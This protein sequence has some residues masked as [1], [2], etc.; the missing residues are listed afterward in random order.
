[1]RRHTKNYISKILRTF[2]IYSLKIYERDKIPESIIYRIIEMNHLRMNDKNIV[3]GIDS[4]Y[5]KKIVKFVRDFGFISV[6]EINGEIVAGL[7]TYLIKNNYFVEE[8]SS[9]PKFDQYNVGH[10]C[11]FLTI[12]DCIERNGNEFHLLWGNNPYKQR[13]LAERFQ[14]Y[15]VT[16]F[17]SNILKYK[18]KLV[19][20]L[21]QKLSFKYIFKFLKRKIKM[22]LFRK[23]VIA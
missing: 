23:R 19:N 12:Q 14:L 11:L 18:F 21:L 20:E 8:I 17:R 22:I 7:I 10:T 5:A 16:L 2:G 15:S 4:S 6:L 3:S 9:D 13:F 1:M